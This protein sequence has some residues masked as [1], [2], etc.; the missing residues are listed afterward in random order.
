MIKGAFKLAEKCKS[1]QLLYLSKPEQKRCVNCSRFWFVH[2]ETP[3]CKPVE[4]NSVMPVESEEWEERWD[5]IPCN[6]EVCS[7]CCLV[8][9]EEEI[10]SF[11][12]SEI[13]KAYE[14]G[15]EEEAIGCH[16][17]CEKAKYEERAR[18]EKLL[19][20]VAARIPK[21][22]LAKIIMEE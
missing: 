7:N 19:M 5:S 21:E 13:Q 9:N 18:I 10:K 1:D 12:A 4:M 15:K 3:D 14:R 11:I 20:P 17:H 6:S 2:E 22:I 8:I 16:E